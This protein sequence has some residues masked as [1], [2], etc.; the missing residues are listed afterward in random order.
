VRPA[1]TATPN[2]APMPHAGSGANVYNPPRAPEVYTIAPNVNDA[3]PAEARELYDRDEHGRILFFTAPPVPRSGNGLAPEYAGLGHST[4]H[5]SEFKQHA[6]ERRRQ[7]AERDERL[8]EEA[9]KK[10][11][12]EALDK[13][14]ADEA[15]RARGRQLF[16]QLVAELATG[17]EL[18]NASLDGWDRKALMEEETRKRRRGDAPDTDAA[19]RGH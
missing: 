17:S 8:A 18:I 1:M 7:R 12:A 13:A 3:I 4:R 11:T 16:G 6:A 19:L 9:K 15:D 5:L 10:A 14:Q 2:A